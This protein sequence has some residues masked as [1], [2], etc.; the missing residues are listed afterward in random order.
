MAFPADSLVPVGGEMY[1]HIHENPN[2]NLQRDHFWSIRIDFAPIEYGDESWDCSAAS[3]WIRFNVRDWRELHDTQHERLAYDPLVESSFYMTEH[4]PA[5]VTLLTLSH[6]G[7]N[8]FHVRMEMLVDFHGYLGGDE[9]PDMPVA[10]ET[11]IEYTGL[12][13]VPENL[14]PKPSTV[15]ELNEVA[16]PFVDLSAYHEPKQDRFRFVFRPKW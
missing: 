16:S 13:I 9:N 2:A 1:S 10:A 4:D 8:R 5:D 7:A 15:E 11:E 12:V 6:V 3:E 14:F